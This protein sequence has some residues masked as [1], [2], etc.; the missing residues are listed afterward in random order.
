MI[1]PAIL[2]L[3]F[4]T[5]YSVVLAHT[6]QDCVEPPDAPFA[7]RSRRWDSEYA[8]DDSCACGNNVILTYYDKGTTK[9]VSASDGAVRWTGTY[10]DFLGCAGS[11][12]I[13]LNRT[14]DDGSLEYQFVGLSC[15]TGTT[16]WI[17]HRLAAMPAQVSVFAPQTSNAEGLVV[18]VVEDGSVSVALSTETGKARWV[19]NATQSIPSASGT[20]PREFIFHARPAGSGLVVAV[21]EQYVV[22]IGAATG[23]VV[24]RA[25]ASLVTGFVPCHSALFWKSYLYC[26]STEGTAMALRGDDGT[27]AGAPLKLQ[28]WSAGASFVLCPALGASRQPEAV[29]VLCA[30]SQLRSFDMSSGA[31]LAEQPNVLDVSCDSATPA[32][33]EALPF[34]AFKTASQLVFLQAR[35]LEVLG[36]ATTCSW[37]PTSTA[38][39]PLLSA[40][41]PSSIEASVASFAVAANGIAVHVRLPDFSVI[42]SYG[43]LQGEALSLHQYDEATPNMK[44]A[45]SAKKELSLVYACFDCMTNRVPASTHTFSGGV[46]YTLEYTGGIR[47]AAWKTTHANPNGTMLWKIKLEL[48]GIPHG[49]PMLS[50]GVLYITLKYSNVVVLLNA[51]SGKLIKTVF[52]TEFCGG[53]DDPTKHV[54]DSKL[55][56]SKKSGAAFLTSGM[57]CLYRVTPDGAVASVSTEDALLHLP[58]VDDD[59]DLVFAMPFNSSGSLNAVDARTMKLVWKATP[60]AGEVFFSGLLHHKPLAAAYSN[61]VVFG[62]MKRRNVTLW[63]VSVTSGGLLWSHTINESMAGEGLVS[64]HGWGEHVLVA[65]TTTLMLLGLSGGARVWCSTVGDASQVVPVTS[66]KVLIVGRS[67]LAMLEGVTALSAGP[68]VTWQVS[69]SLAKVVVGQ[70][71]IAAFHS[72]AQLLSVLDAT[73]GTTKFSLVA[74]YGNHCFFTG[75]TLTYEVSEGGKHFAAVRIMPGLLDPPNTTAPP[76]TSSGTAPVPPG[77]PV[78]LPTAPPTPPPTYPPPSKEPPVVS[79]SARVRSQEAPLLT[80]D[81]VISTNGNQFVGYSISN[82]TQAAWIV[83]LTQKCVR[84]ATCCGYLLCFEGAGMRA[85]FLAT[86]KQAWGVKRDLGIYSVIECMQTGYV[87]LVSSVYNGNT[88]T[89]D[90]STGA[91]VWSQ[92]LSFAYADEAIDTGTGYLAVLSSTAFAVF[93]AKNGSKW[94]R[95][96]QRGMFYAESATGIAWACDYKVLR[97]SRFEDS[98]RTVEATRGCDTSAY[99]RARSIRCPAS[100]PAGSTSCALL[101]RELHPA[102]MAFPSGE[103]VWEATFESNQ[104]SAVYVVHGVP[105]VQEDKSFAFIGLDP[106]NG[107]VRWRVQTIQGVSES[108]SALT[109]LPSPVVVLPGMRGMNVLTGETLWTFNC[110]LPILGAQPPVL[111]SRGNLLAASCSDLNINILDLVK[112]G[113]IKFALSG[114][115]YLVTPYRG[116]PGVVEAST[117]PSAIT[118]GFDT[119]GVVFALDS[120]DP[121]GLMPWVAHLHPTPAPIDPKVA[122]Y[123]PLGVTYGE[124]IYIVL[125]HYLYRV[126]KAT[127]EV[128]PPVFLEKDDCD[129]SSFSGGLTIDPSSG[130]VFLVDVGC[131][132]RVDSNLLMSAA[133]VEDEIPFTITPLLYESCVLIADLSGHL[134][135]Y[136]RSTLSLVWTQHLVLDDYP[137]LDLAAYGSI[138]YASTE[139]HVFCLE[140]QEPKGNLRVASILSPKGLEHTLT[141]TLPWNGV[142]IVDTEHGALG[143]SLDLKQLLWNGHFASNVL[144][145]QDHPRVQHC[146]HDVLRG[147]ERWSHPIIRL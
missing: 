42:H 71:Y 85:F 8:A 145:H 121:S 11:R 19:F 116:N 34:V 114:D 68:S 99:S 92:P 141:R 142:L 41:Q 72:G 26:V 40:I 96:F 117:V 118:Y 102:V 87:T 136:D 89:F 132:Y 60:P 55:S 48:P 109:P 33:W 133:T 83:T 106:Q 75:D 113:T 64:I 127:G 131:V 65:T 53:L 21:A 73:T 3:F 37:G 43:P 94:E 115:V 16:E 31:L 111:S 112:P 135:C 23:E 90:V 91:A 29:L 140:P 10:C 57:P 36:T 147:A 110:K 12:V 77:P 108:P 13:C 1:T 56:I 63:C 144:R 82:T 32:N 93:D 67:T 130:A 15:S 143:Y 97:G 80:R 79:L 59:H 5:G 101:L 78:P 44:I 98:S 128:D 25:A 95:P 61:V 52:L 30:A 20:P 69:A 100:A 122:P 35:S 134:H 49:T 88:A 124:Y 62:T 126:H 39:K 4:L 66:S 6:G 119:N 24:W 123:K 14:F 70:K 74:D 58:V 22:A 81:W 105:V 51:A 76:P 146:C 107:Q 139:S 86:G 50:G 28:P 120:R 46:T 125:P 2:L 129:A 47:I 7:F 137:L 18:Y 17:S 138:V 45:L 84:Q 38:A 54:H 9:A 27:L 103:V 104:Y